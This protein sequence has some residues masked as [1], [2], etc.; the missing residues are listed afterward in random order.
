MS[1]LSPSCAGDVALVGFTEWLA[2]HQAV[3]SPSLEFGGCETVRGLYVKPGH[4]LEAG[5]V[6]AS[7]PRTLLMTRERALE[8][9]SLSLD[10][11]LG[12]TNLM[13]LFLLDQRD[14]DGALWQRYARVLPPNIS[15]TLAWNAEA[16]AEL[17][18]SDLAAHAATRARA[19]ARHHEIV[20]ATHPALTPSDWAWALSMVW[21]RSHTVDLGSGR[22]GALVPLLDLFNGAMVAPTLHAATLERDALVLRVARKLTAGE[23]A[24]V[25]YGSGRGLPNAQLLME[26]GFCEEGNPH[27]DVA[28]PLRLEFARPAI[29]YRPTAGS[30]AD[31]AEVAR[32]EA[33]RKLR[34]LPPAARPPRLTFLPERLSAR[35]SA[36]WPRSWPPEALVFA[37]LATGECANSSAI[38]VPS[39]CHPGAIR[40]P[41]GCYPDCSLS[42]VVPSDCHMRAI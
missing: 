14:D 28:L 17:Q 9:P 40:V 3:L 24:T 36:A 15:T 18:A 38:R 21:S 19:V 27:D 16:L 37:R 35:P 30:A 32:V 8:Q 31:A 42:A 6:A 13:A 23:E 20:S 29:P 41:S 11:E 1:M 12:S 34:L 39:E 5:A 4:T 7:V 25:P 26:Y 2:R 22:Q 10:G 33:L